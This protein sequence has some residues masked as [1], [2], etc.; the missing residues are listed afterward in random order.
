MKRSGIEEKKVTILSIL[1]LL[2]NNACSRESFPV[3]ASHESVE[4]E[5][6]LFRKT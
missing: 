1:T 5:D 2:E 6:D 4:N 3:C